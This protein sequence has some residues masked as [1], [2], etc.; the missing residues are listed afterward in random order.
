[1]VVAD[2][3]DRAAVVAVVWLCVAGGNSE[4]VEEATATEIP[5]EVVAPEKVDTVINTFETTAPAAEDKKTNA[6]ADEN[7]TK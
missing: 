7:T 3:L 2:L 4:N 1:M 5:A 6:D